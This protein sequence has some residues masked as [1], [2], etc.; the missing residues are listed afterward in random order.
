[1][2]A[3]FDPLKTRILAQLHASERRWQM[4]RDGY[5]YIGATPCWPPHALGKLVERV[6]LRTRVLR[7]DREEAG[8]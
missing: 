1:M 2:I 5:D 3:A 4:E 7:D 6:L 8:E